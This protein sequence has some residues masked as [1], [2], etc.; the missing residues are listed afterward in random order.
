MGFQPM[1]P[2]YIDIAMRNS[3]KQPV[4]ED[5]TVADMLKS[6]KQLY[7]GAPSQ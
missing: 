4:T 7:V 1:I 2:I 5:T 3:T 6:L